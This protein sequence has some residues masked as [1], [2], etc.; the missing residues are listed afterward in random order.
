M[1]LTVIE[2]HEKRSVEGAEA[3]AVL[4]GVLKQIGENILLPIPPHTGIV[5]RRALD[6]LREGSAIWGETDPHGQPRGTILTMPPK[7]IGILKTGEDGKQ[8]FEAAEGMDPEEAKALT[9]AINADLN[10]SE[11]D[12]PPNT[13]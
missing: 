7:V 6:R 10:E 12:V 11:I 9:E 1:K 4:K 13:P 5:R 3:R 2:K 8:V